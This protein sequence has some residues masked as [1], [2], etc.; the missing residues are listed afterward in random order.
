MHELTVFVYERGA[1]RDPP[2]NEIEAARSKTAW[3]VVVGADAYR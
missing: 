2:Q 3:Q 1:I